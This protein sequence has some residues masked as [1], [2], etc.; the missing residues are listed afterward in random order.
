MQQKNKYSLIKIYSL[1][2]DIHKKPYMKDFLNGYAHLK[3]GAVEP[4]SIREESF[5]E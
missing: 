1:H 2:K 5:Y 3:K 4:K